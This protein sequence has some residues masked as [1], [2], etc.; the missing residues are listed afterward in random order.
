MIKYFQNKWQLTSPKSKS[1]NDAFIISELSWHYYT[2]TFFYATNNASYPGLGA[3]PWKRIWITN[4]NTWVKKSDLNHKSKSFEKKWIR[5]TNP[6][7]SCKKWFV[8]IIFLTMSQSTKKDFMIL[9]FWFCSIR[10]FFEWKKV[11]KNHC[12][13]GKKSNGGCR[14]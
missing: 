2:S 13:E 14:N 10:E 8:N 4:L 9:I 5:I 3:T 12:F 11:Q 7:P 1:L 6:N